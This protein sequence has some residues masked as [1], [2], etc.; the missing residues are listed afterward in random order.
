[1]TNGWLGRVKEAQALLRLAPV[2]VY[3]AGLWRVRAS[4]ARRLK[5]AVQQARSQ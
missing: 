3:D 5:F 1:M 4:V 2:A